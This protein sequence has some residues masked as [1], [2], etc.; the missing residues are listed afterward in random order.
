ML[1]QSVREPLTA[2]TFRCFL[3]FIFLADIISGG[4]RIICCALSVPHQSIF[5]RGIFFFWGKRAILSIHEFPAQFRLFST[6][7]KAPKMSV[8]SSFIKKVFTSSL[9]H[10]NTHHKDVKADCKRTFV[11][12]VGN[13]TMKY[14]HWDSSKSIN[15]SSVYKFFLMPEESWGTQGAVD[16]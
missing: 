7:K 11:A 14:L 8:G 16:P 2:W 6:K 10:L 12:I 13:T 5:V 9:L 15:I 3:F 1:L 4:T